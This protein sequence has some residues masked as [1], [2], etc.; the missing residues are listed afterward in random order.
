[1]TFPA[2]DSLAPGAE[3]S[4]VVEASA[5]IAGDAQCRVEVRS[6]SQKEALQ[7][8][9]PTRIVSGQGRPFEP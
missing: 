5:A 1:V 6:A 3:A 4:F 8:V 9:E 2:V 7:A